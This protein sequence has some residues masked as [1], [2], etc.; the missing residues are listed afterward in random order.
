MGP[1]VTIGIVVTVSG[2]LLRWLR[3]SPLLLVAGQLVVLGAVLCLLLTNAPVPM[4]GAWP[5]LEAAFQGAVAS[6]HQY[7]APVPSDV[8]PIDPILIAAG[9]ACMLLVD[10]VAYTMRR[11][12][13]AGLPLLAI[14]VLPT[15]LVGSDVPWAVFALTA[16]G[17]L[18]M[19]C[20]QESRQIARWGRPWGQSPGG[21]DRD[22]D[23][24]LARR[25]SAAAIGAFATALA[26]VAPAFIPQ[27]GVGM[28]SG[29]F[30]QRGGEPID[31]DNPMLDMTRDL[32]QGSDVDLVKVQTDDPTPGYLRIS[33]FND[34]ADNRWTPG[35]RSADGY[36][37]GDMPPIQ[38]LDPTVP[39]KE[40]SYHVQA[41]DA[42]RYRWLPTQ[43]PISRIEVQGNWR[44]DISTMD[45]MNFDDLTTE[46]IAYSMTA[47]V[48]DLSG[49]EI[50]ASGA[51][52]DLV[53]DKFTELPSGLPAIVDRLATEVTRAQPTRFH[54]AVALQRFFR[55]DGGFEYVKKAPAG[56]GDALE[57]FL[58]DT[59]S[60]GRK[61]FC[62]QFASAMAVMARA[63]DIPARLAIGFLK[64]DR[65][66]PDVY[67]YSRHDLHA[68]PEL[69]FPGAGWVRF[70]PTPPSIAWSVPAYTK[71]P[72]AEPSVTDLPTSVASS[73]GISHPREPSAA[74]SSDGTVS[75]ARDRRIDPRWRAAV[76]AFAVLVLLSVSVPVPRAVRRRRRQRRMGGGPELVWFEL[77]DTIVD[78]GLR[79]PSGRSPRETATYLV[80]YFGPL[81]DAGS[82][83][84][85]HSR[86]D[87]SPQAE[88][89]LER[90]VSTIELHR[91]ARPGREKEAV[92]RADAEAVVSSIEAGARRGARRRA[93]WLPR[94][95]VGDRFWTP[96]S[97]FSRM[98]Q[99]A[100]DEPSSSFLVDVPHG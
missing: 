12:A 55:E 14:Y 63:I 58:D 6:A 85:P 83:Q 21:L 29:G 43:A 95:L 53:D 65:I 59:A 25:F 10:M 88:R 98:G 11:A 20:Q 3:V 22:R 24:R 1:L 19:L 32:I 50:L 46:G 99:S 38:G 18:M 68:W 4:G 47:V 91:Y 37:A 94:S 2:T 7:A 16:M 23:V 93:E 40:Y 73:D 74:S 5:R 42:F 78:L 90:I 75:T 100:G 64:P 54:K 66:G 60:G 86:V 30:G 79:W 13:L 72:L 80:Q 31:V 57:T 96:L 89:A 71:V 15:A 36:A 8:A 33:V 87:V 28:P 41:T 27:L 97:G 70:E 35:D 44:Y 17:F 48:P 76:L 69:Y 51:A 82:S 84:R 52:T 49:P 92:L 62:V 45:V 9:A 61:G 67:V 56:N 34:F 26:I 81:T 77:R 39:I